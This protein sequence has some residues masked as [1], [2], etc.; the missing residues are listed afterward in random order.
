MHTR[1]YQSLKKKP[2]LVRK[3]ANLQSV[4]GT[5]LKLDG[6]VTLSFKIGDTEIKHS[7]F[8]SPSI[9]RNFI[10]GRD[11]LVQN[12]VRLYF[13]LGFLRI[14]N[15]QVPLEEDIHI[16]SLVRLRSTTVLKPQTATVCLGKVKDSPEFPVRNLYTITAVETNFI[17][18]EPGLMVSNSVA[19]L[20]NGRTIPIMVVNNTN[21]TVKLSRGCVI[22]KMEAI[23]QKQVNSLDS[24]KGKAALP[25]K[26]DWASDI[27]VPEKYQ[28]QVGRFLKKHHDLFA[29]KD[30]DLGHTDTVKMKID[31]GNQSP[32]KL[33]PYRTPIHIREV[34]DKAVD[35]MLDANVIRRSKSPWSF[36][37][38][39]VDKKDGSKRFCVDFRKLNQITKPN[40]YPLPL[41]DDILALLGK[42]KIFHIL[43]FEVGL[44]A[45]IDG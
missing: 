14:G 6:Y 43:R 29:A 25:D 7:F 33:R 4:S 40:S 35:E 28:Q 9:N 13:D 32:I 26:T 15:T 17:G 23:N 1:V 41:I 12:G 30:S 8:V 36:P 10:L 37:V 16:S 38:V 18:S 20:N 22:A 11:W 44:L 31:T 5:C 27:E 39:I 19:K 24:I 42:A 21:R 3:I 45:G 34:I 2:P